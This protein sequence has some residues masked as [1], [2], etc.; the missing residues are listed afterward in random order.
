MGLG[1]AMD[2]EKRR[3][4]LCWADA[5]EDA[6]TVSGGDVLG[7]EAGKEIGRHIAYY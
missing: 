4:V 5:D 7:R 6:R 3:L 2:E 1:E